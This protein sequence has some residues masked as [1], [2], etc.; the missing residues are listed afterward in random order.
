MA[1]TSD[2]RDSS[3]PAGTSIRTPKS[4]QT[5]LKYY[6]QYLTQYEQSEILDFPHIYFIG[7]HARKHQA[8]VTIPD[9]HYQQ[10]Y[11]P[12]PQPAVPNYGYD[13]ENGDYKIIRQDHLIYRYEIMELLGQ[14]SFGQVVK[15]YDHRTGATVAIKLIR[16]K[17][18][19]H[20]QALTEIKIL[21]N[22]VDWDPED[23]HHNIRMTD[24]FY[25]RHH[26]CIAFECMSMN[27]YEFIKKN[28]FQGFSV[29]LIRKFTKQ[30]LQSL[31][32]LYKHR[33]VH[34]DLKPE[35]IL[36]KHPGKNTIK[37]IDFG[38]SCLE[39][40]RVYTYIQS[41]F[42]RS[43]EVIL[44]ISYNMA[45]DMWSVG[46]ILAE[47]H[48]GIPIFPGESEQEQLGCIMEVMGLPERYLIE[49]SSRRKLF[50]DTQG[51][52]RMVVNSKGK[53]RR[54]GTKSLAQ[55]IGSNDELFLDFIL[56]CLQWDPANRMTPMEAME[57]EW[58]QQRTNNISSSN[59][60]SSSSSYR[61]PR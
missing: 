17:K 20:A 26:L 11:Q 52:A 46:C 34:C 7:P 60:A 31:I 27:L 14:G 30:I 40:E 23:K 39:T 54:P 1:I 49:Q 13:D 61:F 43:P 32:L 2:D 3:T 42:Y 44:G 25:F 6:S 15:C 33:V 37:V 51:N 8:I 29:G 16:N 9:H 24:Y 57:H 38:S 18:R 5:A 21:Q 12:R 22:L 35:N 4:P 48:T 58:I 28:N 59:I 19:F 45:I 55:A 56:G 50:F 10:Q 47:L 36:L 53:R 41:R